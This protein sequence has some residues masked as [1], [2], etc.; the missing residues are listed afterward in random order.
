MLLARS[1]TRAIQLAL[2]VT[3]IVG[4]V[5]LSGA[6]RAIASL[7]A[8]VVS[9]LESIGF[10]QPASDLE[11]VLFAP[12]NAMTSRFSESYRIVAR[13]KAPKKDIERVDFFKCTNNIRLFPLWDCEHAREWRVHSEKPVY[14]YPGSQ[15]I[16]EWIEKDPISALSPYLDLIRHTL[17]TQPKNMHGAPPM[18]ISIGSNSRMLKYSR[19]G[20]HCETLVQVHNKG[21]PGSVKFRL[22]W[23][24]G[25]TTCI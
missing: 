1:P 22:D 3:M 5:Q 9:A 20:S 4:D 6:E 12:N 11:S 13:N 2:I 24:G 25:F 17:T 19:Y 21:E 10:A 16:R 8:E 15:E 23:N 18:S 14:V 7:P